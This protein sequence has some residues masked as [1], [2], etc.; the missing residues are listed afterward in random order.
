MWQRDVLF[1]G[2]VGGGLVTLGANL[3]PPRETKPVTRYDASAVIVIRFDAGFF[4]V[5]NFALCDDLGVAFLATG[6]ALDAIKEQVKAIPP[7][8]WKEYAN[9]QQVW[10]YAPFQYQ[11][12]KWPKA[13]RALYTRPVYEDQ[14]RLLDFARPDLLGH[15]FVDLVTGH[16]RR[17]E[18]V[19]Q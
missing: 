2:L 7:K 19:A 8:K 11:C 6:K 13:Y 10:S 14:Q 9:E 15:R 1:L 16:Q 3:M 5:K 18:A 4:D 17:E 12:D